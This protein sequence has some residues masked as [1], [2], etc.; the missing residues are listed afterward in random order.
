MPLRQGRKA[1]PGCV[2]DQQHTPQFLRRQ[3]QRR[4]QRAGVDL[5]QLRRGLTLQTFGRQVCSRQQ[6][7]TSIGPE[8]YPSQATPTIAPGQYL[9]GRTAFRPT[10]HPAGIRHLTGIGHV[11]QPVEPVSY[12]SRIPDRTHQFTAPAVLL[13]RSAARAGAGAIVR[14]HRTAMTTS[15]AA[16][17]RPAAS[18]V[19]PKLNRSELKAC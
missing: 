15:A 2:L 17:A 16:R 3:C 4:R 1:C 5:T 10:R 19:A 14:N 11:R 7:R 8:P 6:R 9:H 18:V 13:A 12:R